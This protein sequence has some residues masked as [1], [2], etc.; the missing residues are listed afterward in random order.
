M[1]TF[2][3]RDFL[4][5]VAAVSAPPPLL[6]VV[7]SIEV[8]GPT[9]VPDAAAGVGVTVTSVF[10][11]KTL[12][13]GAPGATK[14]HCGYSVRSPKRVIV[15]WFVYV[16]PEPFDAVFQSLN[17]YPLR[18]IAFVAVRNEKAVPAVNPVFAI[19]PL[20]TVLVS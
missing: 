14:F 7:T 4:E 15:C 20:V 19:V 12:R 16:V 8:V 5:I 6:K 17:V 9:D 1:A 3:A 13:V 2:E 18:E 10:P 11:G